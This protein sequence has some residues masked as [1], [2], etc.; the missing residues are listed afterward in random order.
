MAVKWWG[1]GQENRERGTN[2]FTLSQTTCL[3]C[4][5]KK[6]KE[7]GVLLESFRIVLH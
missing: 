4:S 3:K 7:H 5:F 2:I 6:E 1:G